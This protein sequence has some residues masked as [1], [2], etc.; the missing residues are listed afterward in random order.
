[1]SIDDHVQTGIMLERTRNNLIKASVYVSNTLGKT[2]AR[3][4][5]DKLQKAL[6]LVDNVRTDMESE[7]YKDQNT[8]ETKEYLYE[9]YGYVNRMAD[10]Y[11]CNDH[12]DKEGNFHKDRIP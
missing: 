2:K 8:P 6:N 4:Q 10:V 3:K 7:M 12:L 9:K 1:M 11:C 5:T